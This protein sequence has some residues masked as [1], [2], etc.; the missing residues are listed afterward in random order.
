MEKTI[1]KR[2]LGQAAETQARLFL[3]EQGLTFVANNVRSES[4]EEIDLIMQDKEWLVFIEVRSRKNT[5]YGHPLDSITPQKQR[6]IIRAATVYLLKKHIY[7]KVACRFD[8][9]SLTQVDED[10]QLVWIK[11]AFRAQY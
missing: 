1:S 6:H 4:Q 3:E 11:D 10:N 8:V 2:S 7:D 5:E 9:V